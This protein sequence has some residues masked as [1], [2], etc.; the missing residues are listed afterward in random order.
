MSD[1]V[2]RPDGTWKSKTARRLVEMGHKYSG[3]FPIRKPLPGEEFRT[4]MPGA[5]PVLV[6][7][8]QE[9]GDESMNRMLGMILTELAKVNKKLDDLWTNVPTP[10]KVSK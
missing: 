9:T 1:V 5:P 3:A 10:A 2:Q 7:K 6:F 4:T 8:Q